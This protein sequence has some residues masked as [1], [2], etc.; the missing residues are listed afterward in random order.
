MKVEAFDLSKSIDVRKLKPGT[1]VVI[2]TKNTV[3]TFEII[4]DNGTVI[5]DGGKYFPKPIE[6]HFSGS[7]FGGSML[8]KGC[9]VYKMY[10]EIARGIDEHRAITTSRVCEAKIIDPD[11]TCEMEWNVE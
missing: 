10:M 3:Y 1:I 7:T 4:D 2:E 8:K 5:V 9:I 6:T 11:W